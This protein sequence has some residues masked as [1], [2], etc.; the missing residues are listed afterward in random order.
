MHG[1]DAPCSGFEPISDYL[2]HINIIMLPGTFVHLNGMFMLPLSLYISL[3]SFTIHEK[4]GMI[5]N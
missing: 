3:K 2:V 4:S 1:K 5:M